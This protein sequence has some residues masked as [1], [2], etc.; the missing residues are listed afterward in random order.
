MSSKIWKRKHR[1]KYLQKAIRKNKRFTESKK[2]FPHGEVHLSQEQTSLRKFVEK[3][4]DQR[5]RHFSKLIPKKFLD[6]TSKPDG[7]LE[8]KQGPQVSSLWI[9]SKINFQRNHYQTRY[10][11]TLLSSPLV[12]TTR[13]IPT[14]TSF[15]NSKK[16]LNRKQKFEVTP[17]N[18]RKNS[19]QYN[20]CGTYNEN[21]SCPVEDSKSLSDETLCLKRSRKS[22]S[23]ATS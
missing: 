11:H 18:P 14:K 17:R 21:K 15:E 22:A 8:A 20:G 9:L 12:E 13:D 7:P 19:S 2:I 16:P 4:K 6:K 23:Q 1:K 5:F 10:L 3:T